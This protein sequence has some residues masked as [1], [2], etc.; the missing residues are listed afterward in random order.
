MKSTRKKKL[1]LKKKKFRIFI[2]FIIYSLYLLIL[3]HAA[4]KNEYLKIILETILSPIMI[5]LILAFM[6]ILRRDYD[7]YY[8][9][10]ADDYEKERERKRL[11]KNKNKSF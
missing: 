6:D 7:E 2:S 8:S 3:A 4:L 5:G 1:S 11:S 9:N 10:L